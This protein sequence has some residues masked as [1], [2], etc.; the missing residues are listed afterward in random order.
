MDVKPSRISSKC[1]DN[2]IFR[3]P[4]EISWRRT[5][6]RKKRSDYGKSSFHWFITCKPLVTYFQELPEAPTSLDCPPLS[7]LHQNPTSTNEKPS[8]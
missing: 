4:S 1:P 2:E 7:H 5:Q 3:K 8:F 6:Q